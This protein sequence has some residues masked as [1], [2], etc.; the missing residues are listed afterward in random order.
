MTGTP[1]V[2]RAVREDLPHVA[3]L[4]AEHAAY[5]HAGP[6]APGLAGRLEGL[7]FGVAA[8]RLRCLVAES[9]DGEI[10]G[11][12]TCAPELST[13]DGAEYLHMDCLFL[14]EGR[15]GLGLGPLLM[16]AVLAEARTL[17]LGEVQWQTPLWNE[18]AIRFY[19]RLGARGREKRRYSLPADGSRP[20]VSGSRPVRQ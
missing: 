3:A 9:G 7:L 13:W 1:R 10:V 4:A 17:G 20:P 15:R 5:E 6:P 11:Y 18:G 14:R 19:D 12:A 8:P 16:E 2:R